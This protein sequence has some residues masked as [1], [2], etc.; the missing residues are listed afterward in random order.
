MDTLVSLWRDVN[1]LKSL[2]NWLQW[3]SIAL[4]FVSG[5]FQVGKYVVDRRE[6]ALTAIAQ[7]A[8]L[9]PHNKPIHTGTAT[10]EITIASADQIN[11]QYMDSGGY[12]AFGKGQEAM[13]LLAAGNCFAR[14]NGKNEV[15]WKGVF[16]L[17]ATDKSVGKAVN[18]LRVADYVQ[19]GFRPMKQK[20][21]VKGG[22][23]IVTLNS[24]VRLVFPIPPQQMLG[25][26]IMVQNIHPI[27]DQLQ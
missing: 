25:D 19:I 20:S 22:T 2:S 21:Q 26:N 27:L 5:F 3:L 4:V 13:M 23:A 16:T 11:T 6:K 9:N 10:V 18:S 12:L 7:A 8:Q 17:D 24:A 14:Q 1:A 15:L